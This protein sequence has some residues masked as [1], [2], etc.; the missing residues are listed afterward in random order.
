MM[1]LSE[2]EWRWVHPEDWP[3]V[4]IPIAVRDRSHQPPK[5]I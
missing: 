2:H 1:H 4:M 3:V 5:A